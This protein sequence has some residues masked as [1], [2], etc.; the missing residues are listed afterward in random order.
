MILSEVVVEVVSLCIYPLPSHKCCDIK[1]TIGD[2]H[3]ELLYDISDVLVLQ[4]IR[5]IVHRMKCFSY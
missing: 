4:F 5:T 1:E 2:N 3:I